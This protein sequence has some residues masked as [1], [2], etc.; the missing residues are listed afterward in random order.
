MKNI[1]LKEKLSIMLVGFIRNMR[2]K[3]PITLRN[4]FFDDQYFKTTWDNFENMKINMTRESEEIWKRVEKEF[5]QMQ[6]CML[7]NENR[8]ESN[9]MIDSEKMAT[10][11][12]DWMKESK[13]NNKKQTSLSTIEEATKGSKSLEDWMSEA[14]SSHENK[15]KSGFN[16]ES[17]KM[18]KSFKEWRAEAMASLQSE[19]KNLVDKS[20]FFDRDVM[21]PR[22]WMIPNMFNSKIEQ[23]GMF[24]NEDSQ[25]ITI[26]DDPEKF[27]VRVDTS[28]YRADEIEVN[29]DARII[30][31][32]GKHEE[33]SED[34][35]KMVARQFSRKY[36]L[37][38][39][40]NAE[41]VIS[42]LSSDGVLIISAPKV[43]VMEQRRIPIKSE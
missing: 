4:S 35:R 3:V 1:K 26:K 2:K 11:L 9:K 12:E 19:Q 10:S 16:E 30:S 14:R 37:P 41:S 29:V 32:K 15:C 23:L 38:V 18:V 27:E 8:S 36:S 22:K 6:H 34:G 13:L 20:S 17:K 42:K 7:S 40:V 31:V 28:Q 39:G 21:I 24:K 33:K 43:Q 25:V 5:K